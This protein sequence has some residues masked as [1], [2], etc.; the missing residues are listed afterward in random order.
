MCL[1]VSTLRNVHEE[2]SRIFFHRQV[3]NTDVEFVVIEVS[4]RQNHCRLLYTQKFLYNI[5]VIRREKKDV[6]AKILLIQFIMNVDNPQFCFHNSISLILYDNVPLSK[7]RFKLTFHSEIYL[8][9]TFNGICTEVFGTSD[10][11]VYDRRYGILVPPMFRVL[12]LS[13]LQDP[14][15]LQHL[16]PPWYRVR[17]VSIE[18]YEESTFVVKSKYSPRDYA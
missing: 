5:I 13:V 2:H 1:Y 17:S 7:R 12:F 10:F 4:F 3:H 15:C 8:E 11:T 14:K 6:L 18:R 16:S 9:L